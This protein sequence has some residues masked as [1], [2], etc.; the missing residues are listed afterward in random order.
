MAKKM[1][2]IPKREKKAKNRQKQSQAW[3]SMRTGLITV[4]LVSIGMVVLTAW[5]TIPA[6]GWLEGL[7]WSLGFGVAVWLVFAGF[8]YFNRYVRT[9]RE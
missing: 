7:L 6:L 5:M 9:K 2:K 8:F 3:I 4:T 1:K